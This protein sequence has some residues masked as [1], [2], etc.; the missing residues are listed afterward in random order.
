MTMWTLAIA[1]SLRGDVDPLAIR[2]PSLVA[3]VLTSLLVYA[4]TRTFTTQTGAATAALAYATIG[5]VLQIGR[6]GESEALFALL[7][8][9]SLLLWHIGCVRRWHPIVVWSV[10]FGLAALGAL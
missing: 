6:L 1:G 2:L 8:S 5:Q 10:G 3:V 7:V 9:G 4:Y